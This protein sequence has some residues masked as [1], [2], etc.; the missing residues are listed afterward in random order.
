MRASTAFL[1]RRALARAPLSPRLLLCTCCAAVFMTT[2]DSTVVNVGL[3]TISSSLHASL[4]SLQ[5]IATS[6]VLVRAS[7][8]L[9]AGALGDRFGRRRCFGI[10]VAIFSLGSLCCAVVPDSGLLIASRCLQAVGGALM[11]PSSLALLVDGMPNPESRARALGYWS[12]ATGLSTAAGPVIGGVLVEMLGWRSLFLVNLP[13]GGISLLLTRRLTES[14]ARPEPRPLD[15]VGQASVAAAVLALV[16]ALIEGPSLGWASRGTIALG[17]LAITAGASFAGWELRCHHPLIP[18]RA[19]RTPSLAGALLTAVV[20][21]TALGGFLFFNTLYLQGVRSFS[22]L[23]AG[24]LTMPTTAAILLAAPA[25]GRMLARG[26]ARHAAALGLAIAGLALSLL[27]WLLSSHTSVMDLVGCYLA[28]GIG[29]GLFNPPA[30]NAAV[31]SLPIDRRGVAAALTSTAR[32]IGTTL[33]V[34]VLGAIVFSVMPH[35]ASTTTAGDVA[36]LRSGGAAPFI[37]GLR[38]AYGA[39]AVLALTAVP[40]VACAL[41][42]PSALPSMVP[43]HH[44]DSLSKQ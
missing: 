3:P 26:A 14:C 2:L 34:A 18:L 21:Y 6:Y 4:R 19:L 27:S 15:I 36:Q 29:V 32:Q 17:A 31:S 35:H 28:L 13:I 20:G 25:S 42:R 22:P 38:Y 24:L 7:L 23:H 5:W 33:G 37:H 1:R 41:G 9:S 43:R 16:V 30:T 44:L 39:V 11:T 12:A 40:A 10:G 8:L